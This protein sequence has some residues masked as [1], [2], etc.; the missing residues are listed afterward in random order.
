[1]KKF[2][3]KRLFLL[4][5]LFALNIGN[6]QTGVSYSDELPLDLSA[7]F[8]ANDEILE[9]DIYADFT[10]IRKDVGE[11]P[12]YHPGLLIYQNSDGT[13]N[14]LPVKLQARGN[15][16]KQ[17]CVCNFPPIKIKFDKEQK[18]ST[19]FKN[20]KKLKLVTHCRNNKDSYEQNIL[21]E[22]LIYKAYNLISENS[23]RVKLVRI[24]Y[25]DDSGKSTQMGKFAFFIESTKSLTERMDG[26][27]LEVK[28]IADDKTNFMQITV[29]SIFQYMIGNTDWSVPNLHN[30]KLIQTNVNQTPIAVPYDFDW[31]GLVN[32]SYAKPAEHLPIENVRERLYRGYY[33]N[34][35]QLHIAL[36]VFD[37]QKDAIYG[38]FR[39]FEY[40]NEKE[41]R[42]IVNYLNDFYNIIS[43][44][45]SIE[46]VF[47]DG[48]RENPLSY[49]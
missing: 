13:K 4:V 18:K 33:R 27:E 20:E 37:K 42:Q 17:S 22:Y 1:M 3:R 10:A 41:K 47:I 23:Y 14:K 11:E 32:T 43:D 21:K 19:I 35:N 44:K 45:K 5:F 46:H 30:I 36:S 49:R 8:F 9:I 24:N 39:D 31:S 28:N 16:R 38:L 2:S 15:F 29:L 25:I 6:A 26:T 12:K 34:I 48:A 40:L 7:D